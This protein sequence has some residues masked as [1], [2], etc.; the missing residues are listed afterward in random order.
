MKN[1]KDHKSFRK[2]IKEDILP[3]FIIGLQKLLALSQF[4]LL[5]GQQ[6]RDTYCKIRNIDISGYN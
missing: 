5:T 2:A 1:I 4:P 3:Y 6:K